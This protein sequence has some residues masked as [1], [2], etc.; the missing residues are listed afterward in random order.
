MSESTPKTAALQIDP[1]V[2]EG[3]YPVGQS[4]VMLGRTPGKS[5]VPSKEFLEQVAG[6]G[7]L[8]GCK[9]LVPDLVGI[10]RPIVGGFST[11]FL[12]R[13]GFK[14]YDWEAHAKRRAE[15]PAEVAVQP[16]SKPTGLVFDMRFQIPTGQPLSQLTRVELSR[17]TK[18]QMRK[19][20]GRLGK[21]MREMLA[22]RP[23]VLVEA[24][25]PLGMKHVPQSLIDKSQL[26]MDRAVQKAFVE[27]Y[28]YDYE[29]GIRDLTKEAK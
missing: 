12:E 25:D 10:T 21:T 29:A 26:S 1:I 15:E 17:M 5:Q 16:L 19:A 23:S 20:R 14:K 18:R 3:G 24:A 9:P 8:D 28:F 27:G 6:N 11:E 13:M 2:P 4:V 22:D 7:P